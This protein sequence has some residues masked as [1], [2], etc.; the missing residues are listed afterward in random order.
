MNMKETTMPVFNVDEIFEMAIRMEQ[1]GG[2]FYR[3]AAEQHAG[4]PAAEQLLALAGMEAE[5]EATFRA[6]RNTQKAPPAD[7]SAFDPDGLGQRYL[8]ALAD[9]S[10]AEGSDAARAALSGNE[11]LAEILRIAVGLEK[12]AILFYIGLKDLVPDADGQRTVQAIIDEEKAHV[13]TL[14]QQIRAL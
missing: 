10:G 14:M 9:G 13:V 7:P 12:N 3:K 4:T 8:D 6:M 1:N 11:S 2:A 5:H